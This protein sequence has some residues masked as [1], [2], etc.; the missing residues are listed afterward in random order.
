MRNL[1]IV[2]VL[3]LL[4]VASVQT[5]A[6]AIDDYV[7]AQLKERNISGVS[8]AVVRENR[9]V[10]AAGYGLANLELRVPATTQTVYEI[11]SITKQFTAEAVMLLVETGKLRLDDKVNDYL[12]EK[13]A[14]WKAITLRQILTHTSGLKDWD[15]GGVAFYRRDYTPVEY[16]RLMAEQPLDFAPG[17]RFAYTNTGFPLLGL[18]IERASGLSYEQ[19]V[20]ERIFK[21]LGMSSTRFRHPEEIVVNRADG[22]VLANGKLQRGEQ[23]RPVIIAPNG[24]IMTT[25]LDLAKWDAA[26]ATN[27]LLKPS[28]FEQM[29]QPA[30]LNDGQTPYNHGFAWFMD[31][32]NNHRIVQHPGS[33]V[34]GYSAIIYRYIDDKMTVILLC[35]LGDGAFGV[36]AMAKRIAGFYVPDVYI[37]NLKGKSDPNPQASERIKRMLEDLAAGRESDAVAANLRGNIPQ[38]LKEQIAR[39]LRE[40]RSFLFLD[41]EKSGKHHFVLNPDVER[42]ARYKMEMGDRTVFYTFNITKDGKVARFYSEIK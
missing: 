2:F 41:E 40:M 13:P 16:I 37:G 30:K 3:M 19:F 7:T 1:K 21:P 29:L 18:V 28:S 24:G 36:D 17:E 20:A 27:K 12:S 42:I 26:L 23:A 14:A 6:D 15:T 34:G 4:F 33:T 25:V 38:S 11:G 8:L 5:R 35:N 22:Y 9:I 39:H 10:K 32:F 31:S